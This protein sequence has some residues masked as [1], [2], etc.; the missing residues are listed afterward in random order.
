MMRLEMKKYKTILTEKQ[1]KYLPFTKDILPSN[2]S[3]I[4]EQAK[5]TFSW[6]ALEKQMEKQV[7]ASKSLNLSNKID[8][9]KQIKGIFPK[10]TAEWFYYL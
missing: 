1:Q 6:K 9:L 7:D 4:I 5:F 10:N 3:R 2:W 8:E